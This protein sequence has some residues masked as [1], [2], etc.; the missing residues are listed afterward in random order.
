VTASQ[1]LARATRAICP[2]RDKCKAGMRCDTCT[3]ADSELTSGELAKD[4]AR[5]AIKAYA[6]G[7]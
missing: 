4:I 3:L 7:K 1:A 6:G 5:A 2:A